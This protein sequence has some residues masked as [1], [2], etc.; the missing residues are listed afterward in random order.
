MAGNNS[1]NRKRLIELLFP[2]NPSVVFFAALLAGFALILL[3]TAFRSYFAVNGTQAN[4]VLCI[5]AAIVLVAF[6]GQATVRIGG[7]IAAGAAGLAFGLF[8]YLDRTI[9][10]LLL[11]GKVAN[12]DYDKYKNL[13]I[14]NRSVFLG[15]AKINLENPKRSSYEFIAFKSKIED[16]Q[17]EVKLI[18]Q[19]DTEEV[20]FV[21]V[22]DIEWAFGDRRRLE[23]EF[24]EQ[25]IEGEKR[26]GLFDT[27]LRRFVSQ[28]RAA[29]IE[30]GLKFADAP[31]SIL[32]SEAAA[33]GAGTN[34]DVP[35]LIDRLKSDDVTIRRSARDELA[36]VSV[37]DVPIIF[38]AFKKEF[39][40]YRVKL[41]VGVALSQR[42]R[43][44]PGVSQAIAEKLTDDDLNQLLSAAGDPDRTV[45]AYATEFL[46][47]LDD[48]R[49]TKLAINR[50]ATTT[51]ENA[52]YN[53]L[54]SASRGW[55][56]LPDADKKALLPSLASAR[57][58]TSSDKTKAVID[59]LK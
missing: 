14:A 28:D 1:T 30:P 19:E 46:S 23:W 24:R 15:A 17:V 48:P 8:A 55:V 20:L 32:V 25:T 34:V 6:G 2:K 37:N 9:D 3:P 29:R 58:Q 59:K 54:L 26:L 12:Y 53:W 7:F 5:G 35:I 38:D 49:L 50:A 52:R 4:L 31:S 16:S 10:T 47:G 43:I 56:K 18:T 13:E 45:R 27:H 42:I 11:Q 41:G 57:R 22:G 21:D 44:E 39:G 33:Q 36:K 51:D 40:D